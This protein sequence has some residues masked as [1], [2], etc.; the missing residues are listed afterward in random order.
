MIFEET[1]RNPNYLQEYEIY[2]RLEKRL[3]EQSVDAYVA[4]IKNYWEYQQSG[5]STP[6]KLPHFINSLTD[7]GV[8]PSTINRKISSIKGY[9]KFL[10]HK[11]YT[12]TNPNKE[13]KAPKIQKVRPDCL[14]FYEIEKLY[15]S[16]ELTKKGSKRNLCLIEL[17][18]GAGLRISE[19]IQMKLVQIKW[20]EGLFLIE[21][22]GKKQRLVPMGSK[23]L[24]SLTCYIET[25]RPLFSPQ[26]D[27]LL[28]NQRG[29]SLS[30]MGA[31]KIIQKLKVL[32][33]INT[34][35]SPHTFRHSFATHLIE[36]GADLRAVQELLG[37]SD[38][39]TTQIY[40][41]IDQNYLLEVHQSFHPRNR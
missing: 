21:G 38:I 30:R 20:E 37:H 39:T 6:L 34:H 24:H 1:Q 22:K 16:I 19:A 25:E 10:E 33:G 18:Y 2:L 7:L 28:L 17:L 36:A 12:S 9:S 32:S 26:S 23:V 3:S 40:T 13:F 41:H 11:K 8:S 29:T 27:T 31:W 4:D 14:S 35:M 5:K 15:R